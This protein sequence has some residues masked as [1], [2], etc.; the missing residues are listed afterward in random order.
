[1]QCR[2]CGCPERLVPCRTSSTSIAWLHPRPD[3]FPP[4]T[5]SKP[6]KQTQSTAPCRSPCSSPLQMIARL[7]PDTAR[8][9]KPCTRA[10]YFETVCRLGR[11]YTL[12]SKLAKAILST[13]KW[14]TKGLYGGYFP[15]FVLVTLPTKIPVNEVS[16]RA[17][18]RGVK[19]TG[20]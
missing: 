1:M 8:W 19:G 10:S 2:G 12:R 18:F 17:P 6:S 14:P 3:I 5:P 16:S 7:A 20:A 13:R 9:R 15:A 11:I 4:D